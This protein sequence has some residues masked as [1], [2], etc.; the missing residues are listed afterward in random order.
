MI[1]SEAEPITI[2]DYFSNVSCSGTMKHPCG[3]LEAS[4]QIQFLA[5]DLL[6]RVLAS[7]QSVTVGFCH[8]LT[9]IIEPIQHFLHF[10]L[11]H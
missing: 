11:I 6:V 10:S 3:S 2:Q 7:W 8:E 5:S 1:I 9:E 4:N